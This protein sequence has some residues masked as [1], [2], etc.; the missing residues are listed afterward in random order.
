MKLQLMCVIAAAGVLAGCSDRTAPDT[1]STG[2]TD[3][4][5]TDR[6]MDMQ[7][8]DEALTMANLP[9]AVQNTIRQH[10]PNALV[11]D[12][13]KE[14]RTGQVVYEI[15]FKD[16]GLNPKI[17]VAE[18]GT[19]I[20]SDLGADQAVGSPE[21]SVQV[22]V[23]RRDGPLVGT[24]LADLPAAVLSAIRERAPNAEV[25]DIDKETRSGQVVYEISFKEEGKNPK[26][27]VAE[28]GTIVEDLKK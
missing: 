12:I 24:T 11:A 2:S 6:T 17:H 16:E 3:G 13:D 10:A 18:D 14:T 19:L 4:T 1:T 25:A 20:Q 15:S 23:G 21:T 28:D 26:M 9:P 5:F 8:A 7:R 22:G 27:H